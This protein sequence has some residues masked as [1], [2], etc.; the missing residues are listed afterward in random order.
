MT[1]VQQPPSSHRRVLDDFP[2]FGALEGLTFLDT[3]SVVAEPFACE[4]AAEAGAQVIRLS[5]PAPDVVE[6]WPEWLRRGL[7]RESTFW[8]QE[9][10]NKLDVVFDFGKPGAKEV[11]GRILERVDIWMESSRPGTYAEHY[12]ITDEWAHSINPKLVIVHVSG[13]GQTGDPNVYERASYDLIGQAYS[14]FMSENGDPDG[15]PMKVSP[16]TNDYITALFSLWS[17]LAAYIS[18][19]RTGRGQSIDV[20][21]YEC[22][23]KLLASSVMD[24]TMLGEVHQRAGNF[25]PI[26]WHPYG[27]YP[28]KD[29]YIAIGAVGGPFLRMKKVVPGLDQDKYQTLEDQAT[30]GQEIKEIVEGWLSGITSDEVD[31]ILTDNKV[32][33]SKV[34]TMPDIAE[35]RHYQLRDML[36]EWDDEVV[37]TVKGVGLVP[38]FAETPSRVW[39]GA[40]RRGQ[41]TDAVLAWAGYDADGIQALRRDGVVA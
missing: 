39:R 33:C 34:M 6:T 40:P 5:L 4:L 14:G 2:A 28:T 1:T 16:Y 29:G 20:A 41:D 11:F 38:K 32:P 22:Q 31:R 36:I 23:F 13:F 26:G 10:R 21:Q 3:G 9:D 25:D 15:P 8:S 35:S 12:G 7:E 37:G 18:A 24:Y 19:E 27:V 30:Y 17:S